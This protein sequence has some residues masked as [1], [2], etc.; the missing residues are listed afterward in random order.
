M[1]LRQCSRSTCGQVT[2]ASGKVCAASSSDRVTVR[3]ELAVS[4]MLRPGRSGFRVQ[5]NLRPS[6]ARAGGELVAHVPLAD[7]VTAGTHVLADLFHERRV[8]A[9]LAGLRRDES[10]RII[11]RGLAHHAHALRGPEAEELVAVG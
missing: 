9:R 2:W 1:Y 7:R 3:K 5:R 10:E 8:V 6:L 11:H 4:L